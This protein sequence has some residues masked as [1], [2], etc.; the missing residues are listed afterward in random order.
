[1][2]DKP[3]A[4]AKEAPPQGNDGPQGFAEI[5]DGRFDTRTPAKGAPSG[6]VV[7]VID[8]FDGV[9]QPDAPNGRPLFAGDKVR[10]DLPKQPTQQT[11]DVP[12]S[13]AVQKAGPR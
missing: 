10:L 12:D 8:G 13:A 11:I 5:H 9:A 6:A 2:P 7:L 1:M 3:E 4:Q